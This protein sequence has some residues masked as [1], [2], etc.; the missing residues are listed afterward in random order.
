MQERN[1]KPEFWHGGDYNPEQW[2]DRPDIL[3]KDIEYFKLAKINTVS[4]GIFSWVCLEPSEGDFQFEWLAQIIDNL[5][6]N[7]ISVILATPTGS[8][9]K[10]MADKYPEVLRVDENRQ[11]NLYG[12]R[13][14]HCYTSPVYREKMQVMNAKLAKRFDNHP[15]VR[16]WH[17]SNEYGGECHCPLCQEEFRKWLQGRYASIEELNARWWTTFWSHR[18]S[19]FEQIESPSPRGENG[20]HALHLEWRRFVTARTSDF[21]LA[22][23]KALRD[24][25][26]TKEVTANLMYDFKDIDY[27]Q[28]AKVIDVVSY[29]NYP[30]WHKEPE[31]ETATDSGLQFDIMRSLKKKPFLLMES[32]PSAT[33]WQPISKLKKPGLLKAAS[34]QSIAHGSDSVMYFQM[35]QGRGAC[36]KFHGAVI[37]HYGGSDTRVFKEVSEVGNALEA[38]AEL[39]GSQCL[40]EAAVIYDRNNDW[41][42]R[43]A[44]GPRNKNMYYKEC[45]DKSY[46]ALR[47]QGINVDVIGLEAGFGDYRLVAAPMQYM[48]DEH[49]VD[50]VRAFV[51][52]GGVFLMTYWSGIVDELDRCFL[53][54]TPHG[55]VDV[56]GLRS[57]EIDSLYDWESNHARPLESASWKLK[58]TYE[59][60]NLCDLVKPTTAEVLMEY[61]EDFYQGMPAF[62][63]NQ[64]GQG[65]AYYVCADMEQD[66][67]DEVYPQLVAQAGIEPIINNVPPEVEVTMREND[68]SKYIFVQNFGDEKVAIA[69][70]AKPSE[71]FYG[72]AGRSL[73]KYE[74]LVLKQD[75]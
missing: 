15:A 41:A 18:Y 13:H 63:K 4:V 12:A 58:G 68:T 14:N 49:F 9:P 30:T 28:F 29:D 60:R 48:F 1:I 7:G 38:L 47:A 52:A 6:V 32:C 27:N 71:V 64:Y 73:E 65:C 40:A 53:E 69:G 57:M 25:G 44:A 51:K 37:N 55:L 22:E 5:Y 70:L 10:W 61:G 42:I 24:A 33:N 46:R 74:T 54:G 2:L 50:K 75:K 35:R 31:S 59:C 36:E 11:R 43:D 66:F 8:R 17:L 19:S 34:L 39:H 62:T 72:P 16:M 23:V 3:E 21:V 67:Y 56:M 45:V 26:A 20:T